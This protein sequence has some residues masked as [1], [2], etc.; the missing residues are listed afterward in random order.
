MSAEGC[1]QI[2]RREHVDQMIARAADAGAVGYVELL[3]AARRGEINVVQPAR[4]AVVP[5][6]LLKQTMRPLVAVLGDDDYTSTGPTAW[7]AT[8]RLFR[9]ARGAVIH[10][11]GADVPT[12]RMAISMALAYWRFLLIETDTA[13]M[14]E[15]GEALLA[16]KVPFVCLEPPD[17][18]HPI[19]LSRG[20]LQ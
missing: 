12:Y 1:V 16:Q 15:W 7:P 17:G 9:W 14:R 13:H 18:V 4:D 11:T 6:R 19:P 5:L 10:A 8:R 20:Q 2:T 3:R